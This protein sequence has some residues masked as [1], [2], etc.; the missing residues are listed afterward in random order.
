MRSC[1]PGKAISHGLQGPAGPSRSCGGGHHVLIRFREA[2][3][4]SVSTMAVQPRFEVD[5]LGTRG[6]DGHASPGNDYVASDESASRAPRSAWRWDSPPP[7]SHSRSM[8]AGSTLYIRPRR[9]CSG[10]LRRWCRSA[11]SS[12]KPGWESGW[13]RPSSTSKASIGCPPWIPW[14]YLR[15]GPKR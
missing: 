5:R 12:T 7:R 2:F 6:T 3:A 9:A 8:P 4:S 1:A 11:T 13:T 15:P 10:C 14:V